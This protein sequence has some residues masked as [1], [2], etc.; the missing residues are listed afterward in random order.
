MPNWEERPITKVLTPTQL[1]T[2]LED[3]G[4]RATDSVIVHTALSRF[5]YLPGGE[6]T[7]VGVLKTV[8]PQGNIVM[9][10]QTAD[11]SDPATWEFPPADAAAVAAIRAGMPPFDPAT[12]PIHFIGKTPEYFRTLP[13][14]RR[15][16][17]PLCS[18]CAWGQ[19][20]A[21]IV[22]PATYDLPFRDQGPLQ[23]L[24]DLDAKVVA[25]GT[26]YESCTAL[27][28]AESTIGRPT[29][30]ERAPI[31][32]DG[33]TVWVE[34]QDV[35]LEPYDDFNQVGGLFEAAHPGAVKWAAIAGGT[36]AV[37]PMCPLIDFARDYWRQK[38]QVSLEG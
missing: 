19:D 36:I 38:D 5:G 11:W 27:H 17:H 28:L 20:S 33:R 13:G 25:L 37:L 15:S 9:P 6:R 12:T 2:T 3:L 22:A 16:G 18:F 7:V 8:L 31:L 23:R 35:A 14:T 26:D 34:Y 29:H 24:Y 10:A 32:K 30:A 4:L 21:Q 1:Q